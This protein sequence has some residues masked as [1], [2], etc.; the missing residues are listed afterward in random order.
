MTD[1]TRF[2][3]CTLEDRVEMVACDDGEYVLLSDYRGVQQRVAE[4]TAK[5]AASETNNNHWKDVWHQVEQDLSEFGIKKGDN[6]RYEFEDRIRGA[7]KRMEQA[8]AERDRLRR[9]VERQ[10]DG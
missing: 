7:L 10:V 5:L 4:L 1:V 2:D 8:E 3:L 6:E 9:L